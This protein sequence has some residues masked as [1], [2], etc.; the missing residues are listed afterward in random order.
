MLRNNALRRIM[1]STLA[2]IIVGILY[3]FPSSKDDDFSK[4]VNYID[5]NI[6]PIY[7]INKDNFVVR[8]TIPIDNKDTL[9]KAQELIEALKIDG[10]KNEYI[11]DDFKPIIPKNTNILN[12]SIEKKLLKVNFSKEFLDVDKGMEEKLIEAL[13]YTL[14][15]IDD[16]KEIMIFVDGKVLNKLPKSNI[17]LPIPLTRDFGINK[18]YDITNIKNVVKTT[19][20]YVGKSNNLE[21]YIPITKIDNNNKDK[22]EIIIEELKSSPTYETNLI[23]YLASNTELLNYEILENQIK[24]SF[25]NAI[26]SNLNNDNILEEVKYSISMSLKDTLNVDEV[27]FLVDGKIY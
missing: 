27:V 3:F 19:I 18:I 22:I 7:V 14:T 11:A 5:A 10:K 23:S 12:I 21:Y 15:E 9:K 16:I 17:S 13:I 1:V 24:L 20:Y 6:S 25:N 26:L 2:L 8:T 4:T